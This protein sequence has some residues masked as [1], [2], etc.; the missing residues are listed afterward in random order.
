MS[1]A[2]LPPAQLRQRI[3]T[4]DFKGPAIGPAIGLANGYAQA[5]LLIGGDRAA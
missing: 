3:R 5:N 1:L 4:G 2:D